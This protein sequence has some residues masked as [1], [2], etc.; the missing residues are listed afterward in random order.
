MRVTGLVGVQLPL[1]MAYLKST[2]SD[3]LLQQVAWKKKIK[4]AKKLLDETKQAPPP[5]KD[6][7]QI[8]VTEGG[9]VYRRFP[10]TI[11]GVSQGAIPSP[12]E[13]VMTL[14]EFTQDREFQDEMERIF[15]RD[16]LRRVKRIVGG[17]RDPL[18]SLPNKILTRILD[19][20]DLE[21]I[22]QLAKVNHHMQETCNSEKL[23]ERLY[24]RHQG[25]PGEEVRALAQDR[26]WKTVFYMDKL[27]L[28]K[29]LSRRR[30]A[31]APDGRLSPSS[32]F[33][34]EN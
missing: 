34:T 30:R 9:V 15:G 27:Q 3:E 17:T 26:G 6:Y 8:V 13:K 21:S 24:A 5:S 33:L 32:T 2:V 18:T 7:V 12:T 11:R 25:T 16:V 20:L 31:N 23:W 1:V 22:E 14:D 4:Q 19:Y 29:E 10:I 28:R